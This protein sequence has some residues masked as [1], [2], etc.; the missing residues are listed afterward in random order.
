MSE[1]IFDFFSEIFSHPL[2]SKRYR[3][4]FD[5]IMDDTTSFDVPRSGGLAEIVRAK[6]IVELLLKIRF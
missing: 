1:E 2:R 6:S 4:L 5:Y 3:M